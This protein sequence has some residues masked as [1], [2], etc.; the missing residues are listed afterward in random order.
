MEEISVL[1]RKS[2]PSPT[3]LFRSRPEEIDNDS[4]EF[5]IPHQLGQLLLQNQETSRI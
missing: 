5:A 3:I 4:I 1:C 2:N